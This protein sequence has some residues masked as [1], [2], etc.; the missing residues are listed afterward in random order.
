[1]TNINL[2]DSV[3]ESKNCFERRL[4]AKDLRKLSR[5]ERSALILKM[6]EESI[7]VYNKYK[8]ELFVD[9]TGDGIE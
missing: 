4:S 2:T 9:E 1:M 6:T 5:E 3:L 7:P 8:D